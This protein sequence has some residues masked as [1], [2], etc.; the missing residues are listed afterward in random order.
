VFAISFCR[1]DEGLAFPL[2][3]K[4]PLTVFSWRLAPY[5]N[6]EMKLLP[7]GTPCGMVPP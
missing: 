3:I 1:F 4:I 7:Y 2:R 5:V 6:L